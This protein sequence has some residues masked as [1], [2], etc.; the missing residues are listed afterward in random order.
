MEIIGI[1]SIWILLLFFVLTGLFLE[2]AFLIEN[3]LFIPIIVIIGIM[4]TI[5]LSG[6]NKRAEYERVHKKISFFWNILSKFFILLPS[7]DELKE[8][9]T[10]KKARELTGKLKI[11]FYK[12][13]LIIFIITYVLQNV[14]PW[15]DRFGNYIYLVIGLMFLLG[16]FFIPKYLIKQQ[17]KK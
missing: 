7:A 10:E 1:I 15:L 16:L 5:M 3:P 14:S 13:A 12:S 2:R 9:T 11:K 6:G 8:V 4:L 17:I